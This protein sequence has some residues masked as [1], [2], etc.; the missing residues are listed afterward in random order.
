VTYDHY[1]FVSLP[2]LAQI[3]CHWGLKP[4]KFLLSEMVSG[5]T[6][7][8]GDSTNWVQEADGVPWVSISDMTRSRIITATEKR[9]SSRAQREQ[10]L[11]VLQPGTLLYS[12]YASVGKVA[13]L[14]IPA[15]TNQAILGL[16]PREGKLDGQF[17]ER[18]LEHF[19]QH[20]L[21][22]SSGNT[23]EN[24][25]L[26]KSAQFRCVSRHARSRS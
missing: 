20:V 3:P 4:L 24:L 6:P 12:M 14:A 9:I 10:R 5:G 23:Q 22:L 25:N 13:R 18:W 7:D 2:W 15:V 11:R 16:L 19:E 26:R 1:R 17:L 21:Y 8:T